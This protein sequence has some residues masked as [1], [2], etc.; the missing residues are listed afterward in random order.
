MRRILFFHQG[1]WSDF[2]E[3]IYRGL[4]ARF[5]EAEIRC[6]DINALLKARPWIIALNLL[7]AFWVYGWD[8]VR[9]RRDL[10]ESFFG[11]RYIFRKIQGLARDVHRQWPANFSFQ[12][13]SMFDFSGPGTPHFVYTDHTYESCREYPDYGKATWAPVRPDWAIALERGIYANASS[14]FTWSH[15][16]TATLLRA[17]DIP[18]QKVLCVGVGTNVPLDQLCQIPIVPD[19]YCSR[20]VV[21]V[22]RDWERK[23]GPELLAAFRHVLAVH[24][25]ARLTILGC[26]PCVKEEAVEVV[27]PVPLDRVLRYLAQSSVFCMPT[28]IEPFGIAFLEALAAGLPVVALRQG[29]APDFVILGKTGAL[30][31]Q[32]DIEGLARTLTDLLSDPRRCQEYGKNARNL[33]LE[34]YNWDR[35]FRKMGNRILEIVNGDSRAPGEESET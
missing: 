32:G 16:V 27:G 17:Y 28:R 12:T 9:R 13:W 33:V 4:R 7:T 24:K 14:I 35:V 8:M 15:N 5:S 1:R 11:T 22:G 31:E 6:V 26:N 3:S 21:F 30:V 23:G 18:K 20:R 2:N 34:R 19:R 10:D 29:A 25:D